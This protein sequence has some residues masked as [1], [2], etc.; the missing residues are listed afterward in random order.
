MAMKNVVSLGALKLKNRF[1][2]SGLPMTQFVKKV[3]IGATPGT[4]KNWML[5]KSMPHHL[6]VQHMERT[7]I[8]SKGDWDIRVD[9][10][11]TPIPETGRDPIPHVHGPHDVI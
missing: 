9:E 2:K 8:C 6:D 1:E 11:G 5:G 4:V 10:E 7:K 3:D